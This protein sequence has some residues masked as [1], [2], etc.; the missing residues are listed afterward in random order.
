MSA[1]GFSL[2]HETTHVF[3]IG[4]H[5]FFF[6]CFFDNYIE[7]FVADTANRCTCT[8]A[9]VRA[10]VVVSEFDDYPVA[11]FNACE[12]IGP[13]FIIERTATHAAKSLVFN[14]DTVLVEV[15]AHEVTPAPLAVVAVTH[16]AGAHCRVAY[17]E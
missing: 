2:A 6:A 9:V 15:F 10:V 12:Y 4:K 7:G 1:F 13:Q 11:F 3:A 5:G 17:K 8:T 16:C 14:S